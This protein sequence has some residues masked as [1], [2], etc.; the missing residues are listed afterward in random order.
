[1]ARDCSVHDLMSS[2]SSPWKKHTRLPRTCPRKLEAFASILATTQALHIGYHEN[3]MGAH[4]KKA[5]IL[6]S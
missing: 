1:M 2:E 4:V 5:M 3:K 6:D